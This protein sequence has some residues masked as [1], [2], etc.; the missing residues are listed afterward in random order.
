MATSRILNRLRSLRKLTSSERELADFLTHNA[1]QIVFENVTSLAGKT[2]VSKATVVRFIAKLGYDSFSDMRRE[3]QDDARVIIESLPRRYTLK[4]QELEDANDD[5]LG[6]NIKNI[7]RNL[8]HIDAT[9]DREAFNCAAKMIHERKGN[10]YACGFWT[11]YVLAEMFHIMI[12]RIR[13]NSFL[14]GPQIAVMP[15]M[16][17]DVTA[18]DMLIAFFR[19][20]FTRQTFRIAKH[21]AEVGAPILLVTDSAVSPL[22]KH[23][24]T[25]IVVASEGLSIFRSFTAFTAVL[26]ALHLAVLRLSDQSF[27]DRMEAAAELY[28]QF[29]VHCVQP[30]KSSY[31]THRSSKRLAVKTGGND[32]LDK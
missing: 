24:T 32:R 10:L 15:D 23:A 18:E 21:F 13:P 11:S 19:Y 20:P 14:I 25:Q 28:R 7:I 4:K 27:S 6:R 5:I 1:S 8:N 12:K 22:A 16:L 2:G 3:L 29:D 26:E 31:G 30:K 9:I 17:L